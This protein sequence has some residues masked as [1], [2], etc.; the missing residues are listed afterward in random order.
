M[1]PTSFG[2]T[3]LV[4]RLLATQR[5]TGTD[6]GLFGAQDPTFDGAY[7]QGLALAALAVGRDHVRAA[8]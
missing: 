5:T 4:A 3:N 7:R 2:G 6:A 8:R 1:S